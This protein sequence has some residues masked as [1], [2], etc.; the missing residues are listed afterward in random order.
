[1]CAGELGS[2]CGSQGSEMLSSS[3][4]ASQLLSG[5]AGIGGYLSAVRVSVPEHSLMRL[6]GK[7]LRRMLA[8][9]PSSLTSMTF[10]SSPHCKTQVP[11]KLLHMSHQMHK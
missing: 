1:M 5:R 9:D 3:F 11:G 2:G 6:L 4:L 10:E 8:P 7:S